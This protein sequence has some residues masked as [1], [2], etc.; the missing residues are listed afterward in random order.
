MY[1]SK[2][3]KLKP[4]IDQLNSE[5]QL[6]IIEYTTFRLRHPIPRESSTSL[7]GI[8]KEKFPEQF[9]LDIEIKKI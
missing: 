8:W 9:D 1:S 7:R 2:L 6:K 4:L 3:R 5:E